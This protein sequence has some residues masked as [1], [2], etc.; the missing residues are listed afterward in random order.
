M[1][2]FEFYPPHRLLKFDDPFAQADNNVRYYQRII[3]A[4]GD[5]I[6]HRSRGGRKKQRRE[7]RLIASS[8][9]IETANEE[10]QVESVRG[11]A[12]GRE[13]EVQVKSILADWHT[14]TY[15]ASLESY[16]LGASTVIGAIKR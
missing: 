6:E 13:G 16:V 2:L 8:L 7:C 15:R 11:G 3:N 1:F 5:Q 14:P 12:N 9:V 4:K 10:K